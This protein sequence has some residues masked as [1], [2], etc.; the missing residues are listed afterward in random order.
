MAKLLQF[1]KI[2]DP[3]ETNE[4]LGTYLR[5]RYKFGDLWNDLTYKIQVTPL[6]L[7]QILHSG[8]F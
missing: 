1:F 6:F 4:N 7:T 5:I 8:S 3:I 2:R